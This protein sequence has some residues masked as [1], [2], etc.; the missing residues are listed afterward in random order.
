MIRCALPLLAALA[1][2]PMAVVADPPADWAYKPVRKPAVPRID[3]PK[4]RIVNPVDAFLLQKLTAA[5]L[6]F[7]PPAEKRVLLRRITF[8]LTGLP[9]TPEEIDAFLKDTSPDA[10]EKVVDRLIALPQ[11]GER[12]GRHWLDVVRYAD[13]AGCNSDFPV[14][15]LYRY[16]NWVIQ[17]FNSDK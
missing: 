7:A 6:S 5:G 10:F 14:P 17:S 2:A 12:W 3:N 15:D 13:T 1:L 16:R 8:D 4:S 11:Y 9:P